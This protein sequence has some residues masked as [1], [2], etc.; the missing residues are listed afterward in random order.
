MHPLST[1]G[2]GNSPILHR[3]VIRM[4]NARIPELH[5]TPPGQRLMLKHAALKLLV[6][7]CEAHTR[8]MPMPLG[9]LISA[10][11]ISQLE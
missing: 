10:E 4:A 9:D 3:A 2:L 1:C 8:T 6:W 7:Q 5:E 11:S